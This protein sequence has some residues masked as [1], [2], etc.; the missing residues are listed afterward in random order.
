MNFALIIKQVP[1]SE[2]KITFKHH[3]EN[4]AAKTPNVPK[5]KCV[6]KKTATP[7]LTPNSV[8]AKPGK[9]D[10]VKNIN[11]IIMFKL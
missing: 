10:C 4:A 3:I 5:P 11:A 9:I 6:R 1:S 7:D 2:G 8:I